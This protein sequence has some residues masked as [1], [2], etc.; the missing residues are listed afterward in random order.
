MADTVKTNLP[1]GEA[2]GEDWD[3]RSPAVLENQIAAYDEIRQRCPVAHSDYLHWSL[4]R[5]G[6][7]VRVLGDHDTFSNVVS[8]HLSVPNGMDPPEHGRFRRII[9]P[10]FADER[11]AAFEP[12]CREIAAGLVG[13]LPGDGEIELMDSFAHDFA[14]QIQCAF[15]GWPESL[16]QPMRHWARRNQQA[17]LSGDR[18]ATAAVATEF[19]GYIRDLLAERRAM[20]G[21]AP[22]DATTR[23]LNQRLDD[24][25]LT[26]EEIVSIIRNWTVGELATI[27]ASTGILAHYVAVHPDLQQALRTEPRKLPAAIDEILRMDAPLIA[28]RRVT[29]CPVTLGG[30]RIAAGERV[31]ILWASANRDEAVFGDPD[32]YRTDR[33]PADNLLYGAGIHVCP[34]AG[35]ARLEL[36]V[37]MEELLAG[38]DRIAPAPGGQAVRAVYPVGGFAVLPLHVTR[39]RRDAREKATD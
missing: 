28:N 36:R 27:S 33:D 24:R 1:A 4:F 25:A 20:G 2:P 3:P 26:E 13:R 8:T 29:T 37:L 38:T 18:A 7:V 14:M 6:D 17:T 19:D 34:G 31:T 22:D 23:L 11:I 21:K 15:M 39:P 10:F 5:H 16:Q 9:E 35:L 12:D 30:R 32:E